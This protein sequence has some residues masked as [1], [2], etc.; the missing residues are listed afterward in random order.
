MRTKRW[1]VKFSI[2][3]FTILNIDRI[4]I[5]VRWTPT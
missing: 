2:N 5:K 4:R 3:I 1:K